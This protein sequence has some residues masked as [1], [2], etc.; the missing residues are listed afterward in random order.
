M[1]PFLH[2]KTPGTPTLMAPCWPILTLISVL[3]TLSL[4]SKFLSFAVILEYF[5]VLDDEN[6][7]ETLKMGMRP[8]KIARSAA[9]F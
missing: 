6:Y 9:V 5:T 8:E 2:P 3:A 7:P 4:K 1:L